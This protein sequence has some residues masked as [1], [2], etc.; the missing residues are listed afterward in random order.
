[1]Q[2]NLSGHSQSFPFDEVEIEI[3]DQKYTKAAASF[4]E[5][6][7]KKCNG[8]SPTVNENTCSPIALPVRGTVFLFVF[9]S[10]IDY[11]NLHFFGYTD[12]YFSCKLPRL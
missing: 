4:Y 1:M 11:S 10:L 7:T 12:Y 2:P 3:L 5:W 6:P 8:L 9:A